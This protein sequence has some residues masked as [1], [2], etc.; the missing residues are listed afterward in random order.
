MIAAVEPAKVS[1]P[2]QPKAKP[3]PIET[4]QKDRFCIPADHVSSMPTQ[5]LLPLRPTDF[6]AQDAI[7]ARRFSGAFGVAGLEHGAVEKT[8][9]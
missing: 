5:I 6:Q 7:T 4:L 9:I 3:N 8:G 1:P 2:A